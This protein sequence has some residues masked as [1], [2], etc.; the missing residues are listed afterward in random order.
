MLELFCQ[1][2]PI[3]CL[4]RGLLERCFSADR[5]DQIFEDHAREQ[6]TR[7]LLF[8]TTCS[9]L[10]NVVLR[11]F[12]SPHAAYKKHENNL[13][14]SLAAFYDKL[15][16][17]E[18]TV[19]AAMVRETAQ[20]LSRI[21]DELGFQPQP[22]LT[23]YATRILDGN[24]LEAS[25]KRLRVHEGLSAAAL[26][27]KSLVVLDPDR[28]LLVEVFPCEDGH[29][30]ERSLLKAV[31]QTIRA[32]ELWIADRN[33]CTLGFLHDVHEHQAY[34]LLRLHGQ[35]PF[36]E[37]TPLVPVTVSEDGQSILEQVVLVDGR[38][39]R[40]IRVILTT[41]TRDGDTF[42][43]LLTD[44]PVTVNALTVACLYRKR[45]TLETAFQHLESHFESEINTLAYPRAALFGFCLALV[46]YNL[47]SVM[48]AALDSV[49]EKPV[50]QEVSSYYIAHDIS[51]TFLALLMLDEALDW[52]FLASCSPARFAQ[53]L[54]QVALHIDLAPLKK[55]TRGPKKIKPKVPYDPKNPHVSTHQLLQKEKKRNK[56]SG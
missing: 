36:V 13:N 45:W 48:L 7:N 46:A 1:K 6:Y 29:A 50:S 11:V 38:S 26:P 44:L 47:F 53:W 56:P 51:S 21:L 16:G 37:H 27:G 54:R 43:D 30:Q 15:K 22:W 12:P 32:G 33:F 42:I 2:M 17:V 24:C 20:D 18:P 23:G 10:L 41:P 4:L 34:A 19:A 35:L 3:S 52:R 55:H 9:L 39:Y 31:A 5:L 40:R 14:V 49:H 25:E 28:R 8:S